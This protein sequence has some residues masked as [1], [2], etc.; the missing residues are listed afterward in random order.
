[1]LS[2]RDALLAAIRANPEEDTPRL[3]FADWLDEQGDD[4]SRAR[5]EFIRLQCEIANLDADGSDSQPVYEFLR[6]RDYVTR[7][8]ADWTKIDH[9]I[10]RRIT[11]AAR[12]RELLAR[13]AQEWTPRLPKR[14]RVEWLAVPFSDKV[15]LGFHR[16][17]PHHVVLKSVQ[18]VGA[19]A[20]QLRRAA[21][22]VTLT[23]SD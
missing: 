14:A 12:A 19:V 8:S 20:D 18:Q 4:A 1:M 10:H 11:L 22:A 2:D 15:P 21:P 5:A 3:M 17:F 9:G 23:A 6:D 7:P 16:G 13:H